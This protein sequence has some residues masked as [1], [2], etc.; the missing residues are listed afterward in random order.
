ME[1]ISISKFKATCLGLLARVNKSGEPILI[2]KKNE[3]IALVSP[4]PKKAKSR[5][6]FGTAKGTIKIR[7]DIISPASPLEDWEVLRD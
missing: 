5:S 3:P 7:G 6:L 1:T 4:P 2:T